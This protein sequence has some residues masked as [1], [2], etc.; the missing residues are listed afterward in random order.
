MIET[1]DNPCRAMSGHVRPVSE[2]SNFYAHFQI[3]ATIVVYNCNMCFLVFVVLQNFWY[4]FGGSPGMSG[5]WND[6]EWLSVRHYYN[7]NRIQITHTQSF[8]LDCHMRLKVCG[9]V[10]CWY[11]C[12]I[13]DG[14][15]LKL[16][17]MN[18]HSGIQAIILSI[19]YIH[20][21]LVIVLTP[22]SP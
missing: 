16:S 10:I 4:A 3:I 5:H 13:M 18:W 22:Y 15:K 7:K 20:E 2:L 11:D 14:G 1:C 19:S 8:P 12:K 17:H 9:V 21:Y 6:G